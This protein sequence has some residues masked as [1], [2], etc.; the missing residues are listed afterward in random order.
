MTVT[1]NSRIACKKPA[2]AIL[3]L[4]SFSAFADVKQEIISRCRSQMGE[5]GAAMVKGC[6]DMDIKA[7]V[8][9]NKYPKKYD[10]IISRCNETMGEYGYSMIKGCA[11][12]D[13]KAE[14]DLSEY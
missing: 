10:S 5:Y 8:A 14:K 12:Q 4:I 3:L 6:V 13:I 1:I 2:F 11:D 9:L 7:L